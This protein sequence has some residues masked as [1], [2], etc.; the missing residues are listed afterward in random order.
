MKCFKV[1]M[2]FIAGSMNE[3]RVE[4][5]FEKVGICRFWNVGKG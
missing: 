2:K 1:W 5:C 4:K 3:L